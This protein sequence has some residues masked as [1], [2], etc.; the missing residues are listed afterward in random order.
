MRAVLKIIGGGTKDKA[1]WRCPV[2]REPC[3]RETINQCALVAVAANRDGPRRIGYIDTKR[4]P[5]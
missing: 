3:E 4:Q 5:E 1:P 2:S